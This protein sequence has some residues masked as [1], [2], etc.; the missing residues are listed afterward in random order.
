MNTNRL[1]LILKGGPAVL[2]AVASLGTSALA[3]PPGPA[4]L[5][6]AGVIIRADLAQADLLAVEKKP[7]RVYVSNAGTAAM[8]GV[9][10]AVESDRFTA[11]VE[12]S[13]A[14]KDFPSLAPK[15][16]GCFDVALARKG[17]AAGP[18]DA[19][20]KVYRKDGGQT[21]LAQCATISEAIDERVV[22][23]LPAIALDGKTSPAAWG[24]SLSLTRFPEFERKGAA[25]QDAAPARS[26][27]QL[28]A[29]RENLYLMVCFLWVTQGEGQCRV[30]VASGPEAK[31]VTLTI[32]RK[33][34]AISSE[35]AIEGM[36]CVMCDDDPQMRLDPKDP[37]KA[38]PCAMYVCSIPRKALGI[39]ESGV[40]FADAE[41]QAG[42][43][44][45]CWRGNPNT[46]GIPASYGRFVV[47]Q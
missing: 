10:L 2:A 18:C 8:E 6:P 32:D 44:T 20:L 12:P 4:P 14:W 40:F 42:K 9:E 26:R 29:D 1:A 22:P 11:K 33:T 35:P 34:G 36:T 41:F 27:L 7:F 21:A 15:T 37:F 38:A 19:I 13:P 5:S 39:A 31:P 43:F 45:A 46:V 23:L 47:Q 24:R 30:Q 3:A 28:A 16:A 25:W 17:G